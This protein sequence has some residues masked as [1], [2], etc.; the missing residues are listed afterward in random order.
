M[1]FFSY[2]Q[3]Q[4]FSPTLRIFSLISCHIHNFYEPCPF[5]G[6]NKSYLLGPTNRS[7]SRSIKKQAKKS[8]RMINSWNLLRKIFYFH[9]LLYIRNI[10]SLNL[11]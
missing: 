10:H 7:E 11:K 9:N 8:K 1:I 4:Q 6:S 5:G 3:N 2:M